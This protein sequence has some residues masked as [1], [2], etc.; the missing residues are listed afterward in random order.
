[1]IPAPLLKVDLLTKILK[2]VYLNEKIRHQYYRR[3][4]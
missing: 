3:V 4:G 2:I 1:V